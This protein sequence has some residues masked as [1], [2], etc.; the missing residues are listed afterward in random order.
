MI[1]FS[2]LKTECLHHLMVPWQGNA[3]AEMPASLIASTWSSITL[4]NGDAIT[5]P[6][7]FLFVWL[8]LARTTAK[9]NFSYYKVSV[10]VSMSRQW[11]MLLLA[12]RKHDESLT[13]WWQDNRCSA[14]R[15]LLF[16]GQAS[17][18]GSQRCLQTVNF[19]LPPPLPP[20]TGG[21]YIRCG[22]YFITRTWRTFK[23]KTEGLWTG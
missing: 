17:F 23:R 11:Q 7:S 6:C 8:S 16:L 1:A 2:F 15:N 20:C 4:C 12:W 13:W 5:I 3:M 22:L 10:V 19:L 18:S 9:L 14:N 21:Q